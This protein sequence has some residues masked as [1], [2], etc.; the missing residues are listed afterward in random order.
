MTKII[1]FLTEHEN[2]IEIKN[3]GKS[4]LRRLGVEQVSAHVP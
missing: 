2:A 1:A 3:A 4:R